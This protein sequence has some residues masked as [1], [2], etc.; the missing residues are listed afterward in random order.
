[1]RDALR[2]LALFRPYAGWMLAGVA[3]NVAVVL[4]NVALLAVSGWFITS[5]GLAGLGLMTLN[6]FTPAA[7]I[8]GLAVLRTLGRYAERLVTHEATFRLIAGLRVWFYRHLEPLAPARLQH[9]RGGDL[10]SRIRADIDSL[11]NLYL[12]VVAP[13]AGA[14]ISSAALVWFMSGFSGAIAL[15]DAAA[16]AAAGVK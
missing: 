10:L 3:I 1:M 5:M 9:Y 15:L 16:L 4:A 7:A 2:L 14:L 13:T 6:Y 11:D 8:R 12:R